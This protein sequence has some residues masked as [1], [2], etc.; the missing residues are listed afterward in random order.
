MGGGRGGAG[1]NKDMGLGSGY[2]SPS[3]SMSNIGMFG[4]GYAADKGNQ[5][6]LPVPNMGR[7]VTGSNNKQIQ[8][9]VNR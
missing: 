6:L 1:D 8:I 5:G 3:G 2:N 4:G 7:Q 9:T